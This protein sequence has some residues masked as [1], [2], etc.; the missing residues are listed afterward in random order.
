[1]DVSS[2][3][4]IWPGVRSWGLLS[5]G[6][7]PG[8]HSQRR[9]TQRVMIH[10]CIDTILHKNVTSIFFH[11]KSDT[12]NL[13]MVNLTF[14]IWHAE[15]GMGKGD[16]WKYDNRNVTCEIGD[17]ICDMRNVRCRREN[18]NWDI[19]N[20]T[21][22]VGH[23][24]MICVMG[25]RKCG[26]GKCCIWNVTLQMWHELMAFRGLCRTHTSHGVQHRR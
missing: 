17:R 12:A 21:C 24:I 9:P 25:H 6:S 19:V 16:N 22:E 26:T 15:W 14:D 18:S 11:W 20:M 5:E 13:M 8:A 4:G 3:D 1:M 23:R 10:D 2:F 7:Y